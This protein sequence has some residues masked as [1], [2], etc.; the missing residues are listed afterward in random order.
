MADSH[1]ILT[2]HQATSTDDSEE[3]AGDKD[4]TLVFS[5]GALVG[6][7][8]RKLLSSNGNIDALT[9]NDSLRGMLKDLSK[10]GYKFGVCSTLKTELGKKAIEKLDI[11]EYFKSGSS[12]VG[13]DALPVCKPEPGHLIMTVE[14]AGGESSK[15]IVVGSSVTDAKLARASCTPCI[16]VVSDDEVEL[17]EQ[18]AS[19]HPELLIANI[20]DLQDAL[21]Q[22]QDKSMY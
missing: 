19:F 15:C 18:V 12:I 11:L 22:L 1:S 13:S 5:V 3:G 16:I 6:G 14:M 8:Q 2:R 17:R 7:K 21:E 9:V 4:S 20:T 10:A